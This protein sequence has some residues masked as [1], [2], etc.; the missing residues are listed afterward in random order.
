MKNKEELIKILKII[1]MGTTKKE[2]VEQT[3]SFVFKNNRIYSYNDEVAVVSP[4]L[5]FINFE[6]VVKSSQ[7]LSFLNKTK[8]DEVN[9]KTIENYL[10]VKVGRSV[11]SLTKETNTILPIDEVLDPYIHFANP[12][13]MAIDYE[14]WN[15]V[16]EGFID[17][18]N[19]VSDSAFKNSSQPIINCVHIRNDGIIE[20]TNNTIITQYKL[21]GEQQ[22]YNNFIIP[23]TSVKKV[24]SFKPVF[25]FVDESWA[26]F[27]NEEGYIMGCR[28]YGN[29]WLNTDPVF[30][31]KEKE[32][33]EFPEDF[34]EVIQRA[35]IINENIEVNFSGNSIGIVSKNNSGVFTEIIESENNLPEMRFNI[36][37]FI[38]KNFK[39][40]DCYIGDN[41]I[42]LKH[43]NIKHIM[44]LEVL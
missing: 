4:E 37:Q 16:K 39:N 27:K 23:L 13:E 35:S 43:N 2:F 38:I 34:I 24:I 40:Y 21:K 8:G 5:N 41:K 32:K 1:S 44:P 28:I 42:L 36:H 3:D 9:I 6:G 18:L 25:I 12:N 26:Y 19:L 17:G 31:L 11:L 14:R 7:L 10:R 15:N 22:P 30:D 33:I 29:E 20:A